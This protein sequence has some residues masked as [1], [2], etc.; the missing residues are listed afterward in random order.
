MTFDLLGLLA[1]FAAGILAGALPLLLRALG[2]RRGAG[3]SEAEGEAR[4]ERRRHTL[5]VAAVSV[6]V[7]L[8]VVAGAGYAVLRVMLRTTPMTGVGVDQAVEQFRSGVGDASSADAPPAGPLGPPPDGVY[9]YRA[10]GAWATTAPLFGTERRELPP[11]V[12]A[13]LR[14]DGDGWTMTFQYF[15]KHRTSLRF[16]GVPGPTLEEP[17]GDTDGVRFGLAVHTTMTCTPAAVV[18]PVAPG[19]SWSQACRTVST[20]VMSAA[21]DLPS[22]TTLVGVERLEVG[23]VPVDAWHVRRESMVGGSQT[24]ALRRDTWYSTKDGLLLRLETDSRTSGLA[25]H[26]EAIRLELE[27]LSPRR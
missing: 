8:A 13:T 23:G 22:A 19:T 14:T 10:T 4:R 16:R 15:D 18:R 27:S 11:T 2:R 7:T 17:G 1:A 25:D 24:G 5:R 6:G 3:V 20:G 9:T 21:Q 12:P 26:V